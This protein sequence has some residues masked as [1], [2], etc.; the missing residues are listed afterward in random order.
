[1][2]VGNSSREFA[3]DAHSLRQVGITSV[4]NAAEG[5]DW[6]RYVD[7]GASYY[8]T[9]KLPVSYY[10]IRALDCSTFDLFPYFDS[11]SA[12]ID[13]NLLAGGDYCK[14]PL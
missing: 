12:F 14:C 9:V 4:V 5:A 11:V 2:F 8:T 6:C 13:D 3:L 1:M 7:T 10:G